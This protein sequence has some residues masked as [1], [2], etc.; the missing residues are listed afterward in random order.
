MMKKHVTLL[1]Q[2]T[3]SCFYACNINVMLHCQECISFFVWKLAVKP[4]NI[5]LTHVKHNAWS[6]MSPVEP[7][8]YS[9]IEV[10]VKYAFCTNICKKMAVDAT[11]P[12]MMLLKWMK[13][14]WVRTGL[15]WAAGTMASVP[16]PAELVYS[17][18]K[19]RD[20]SPEEMNENPLSKSRSVG[21]KVYVTV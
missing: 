14:N 15:M 7:S 11:Q 1:F 5:I 10:L 19:C 12:W 4:A 13:N 6:Q 17:Q 8:A 2:E 18:A 9:E 16:T 3:I 20:P 21:C